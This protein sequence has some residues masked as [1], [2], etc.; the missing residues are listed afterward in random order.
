MY[1]R[2]EISISYKIIFFFFT[3]VSGTVLSFTFWRAL[4]SLIWNPS[5]VI[6]GSPAATIPLY[7]LHMKMAFLPVDWASF[8]AFRHKSM[9]SW[10]S[11]KRRVGD[12][13]SALL[14][15]DISTFFNILYIKFYLKKIPHVFHQFDLS[16]FADKGIFESFQLEL[17]QGQNY[18]PIENQTPH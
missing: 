3:N 15:N 18:S 1:C 4:M 7:P 16:F 10:C 13:W 2:N 11:G 8:S 5:E 14:W 6:L 17:H 9:N 12:S